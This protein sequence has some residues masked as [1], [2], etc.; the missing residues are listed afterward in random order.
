MLVR[1]ALAAAVLLAL[2]PAA[3]QAA[4]SGLTDRV[5]DTH[6]VR[7]AQARAAQNDAT[8]AVATKEGYSVNVAFDN[9]LAVDEPLARSYVDFLDALPH[10][11]ELAK[12]EIV[13]ATPRRVG[14]LC[15]GEP[16]DGILACYGN[17]Q[18]VVPSTGLQTT[19]TDGTYTTA[20]VLTHEYGHHIAANRDNQGFSAIDYGPKY[21]ASYELVCDHTLQRRLAPGDEGQSY[22]RNPGE[23][24]AE[25]YARLTFPDQPWRW[26]DLL[27]PDA[28][29]LAAARRD[30]LT[31]WTG[32][33]SKRFV[34]SGSQSTQSFD[35]PLTL[36][37]RLSAIVRGRPGSDVGL[38]VTS[39][40]QQVGHSDD[41]GARHQWTMASGCRERPTE[42][43]TFTVT[44]T[45]G[46]GPVTL[47][48]SYPG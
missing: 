30:V 46:H 45:S 38:R 48:V 27:R 19:T 1:F 2:L 39:G 32:N 24:W 6:A 40:R 33:A 41:R 25:V 23:A 15:G 4:P 44:R 35:V 3:A 34:M 9:G 14:R 7:R 28:A 16:V 13:V 26:T 5:A 12:L 10:G 17:Q 31:P 43:L 37:G 47:L 11:T 36:D 18:M 20:Y 8:I 42:T 22:L 29:A 21:W